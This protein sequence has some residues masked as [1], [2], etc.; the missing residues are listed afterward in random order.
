MMM[1]HWF[2][3][4]DLLLMNLLCCCYGSAGWVL[5]V[6]Y[7]EAKSVAVSEEKTGCLGSEKG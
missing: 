7:G 2:K 6:Y 5:F 1:T 3:C 4:N